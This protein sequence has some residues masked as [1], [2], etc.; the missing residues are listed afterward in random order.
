M[1]LE[2]FRFEGM[3][4]SPVIKPDNI[5]IYSIIENGQYKSYELEL[6]DEKLSS[7]KTKLVEEYCDYDTITRTNV[8]IDG[9]RDISDCFRNG[10]IEVLQSINVDVHAETHGNIPTFGGP[11]YADIVADIKRHPAIEKIIGK[12]SRANVIDLISLYKYVSQIENIKNPDEIK[13]EIDFKGI[14]SNFN[15]SNSVFLSNKEKN[16]NEEQLKNIIDSIFECFT[17]KNVTTKEA[18]DGQLIIT[19]DITV[20]DL[21]ELKN[22]LAIAKVNSQ[23]INSKVITNLFGKNNFAK[24]MIYTK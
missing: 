15:S 9:G 16:M 20:E 4:I 7:L 2:K 17:V 5:K 6:D 11:V 19:T 13:K 24:Q 18:V 23:I 1:E 12:I 22:N 8:R 10:N 14:D 3:C 21:K